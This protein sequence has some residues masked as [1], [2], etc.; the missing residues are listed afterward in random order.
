MCHPT[1]FPVPGPRDASNRSALSRRARLLHAGPPG[2]TPSFDTSNIWWTSATSFRIGHNKGTPPTCLGQDVAAAWGDP[3]QHTRPPLG[4]NPRR[5]RN[6][7]WSG[8]RCGRTQRGILGPEG[9]T[10]HALD[11]CT[12][13]GRFAG[14]HRI[15]VRRSRQAVEPR[16]SRLSSASARPGSRTT[17]G[18]EIRCCR[19]DEGSQRGNDLGRPG[20]RR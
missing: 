2:A 12:T 6:V 19:W 16:T 5:H 1:G 8:G 13:T 11:G 10:S 14:P 15:R 20:R 3:P 7:V 18:F 9:R 17:S 4:Y